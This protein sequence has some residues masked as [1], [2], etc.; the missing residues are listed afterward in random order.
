M[1]EIP[2]NVAVSVALPSPRPATT[3]FLFAS[4]NFAAAS[5][6]DVQVTNSVRSSVD[7]SAKVPVATSW[8]D[9]LPAIVG[10]LGVTAITWR[11]GAA[12]L[13]VRVSLRFATVGL[14]LSV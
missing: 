6:E 10:V 5:F 14:Q 3:P 7:A 9:G 2:P 13:T 4:A 12:P 11:T 1:L 8:R